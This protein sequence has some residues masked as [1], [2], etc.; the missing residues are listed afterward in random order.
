[1]KKLLALGAV[2]C[3]FL[4]PSTSHASMTIN[5]VLLNGVA[6]N[7]IQV[8]PGANITATVNATL[9]SGTKWKAT[10]W[11]M[12]TSSGSYDVTCVNSKNGKDGTRNSPDGTYTETFTIKAPAAPGL[13]T[14]TFLGDG[15][16]NCGQTIPGSTYNVSQ[17]VQVGTN[18]RPPVIDS[19]DDIKVVS[20]TPIAVTY[21]NPTATDDVDS[22]V[23]VT[24]SPASGSTFSLGDTTVTC[25]AHDS[26]GNQAIPSLFKVTVVQP[27]GIPFVMASQ[28]DQS[29]LCADNWRNCFT[30]DGDTSFVKINLGLGSGLG[31]GSLK[32][33]TIAK[34]PSSP[35]V[36]QPWQIYIRCYTDS[37]Y[38]QPCTD[39]LQTNTFNGAN[40][41]FEADEFTTS[42]SDGTHWTADF[43]N[44]AHEANFDGTSP[45]TIKPTYYNQ[46]EIK[47]N[48]QPQGAY[49]SSA[50]IPYYTINGL[51]L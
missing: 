30:G 11:G 42:S 6:S 31:N 2:L 4:I 17:A 22:S 27:S 37:S 13:Y 35:Y 7:Q 1:M 49:G 46:L 36:S 23:A 9:T 25:T 10:A 24:C 19:H 16:N 32:S 3:V 34:D 8:S 51:T 50:G 14:V 18:T 40:S 39:W 48:G 47:D 38:T 45:V 29:F 21:T 43:T 5:S 26:A 20:A 44:P 15:A 12:A 33:V 41:N 28:P